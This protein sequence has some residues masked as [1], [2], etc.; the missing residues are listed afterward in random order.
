MDMHIYTHIY[1]YVYIHIYIYVFTP[2]HG[3]SELW[4]LDQFEFSLIA[5]QEEPLAAARK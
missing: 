5:T 3:V 2:H 1:I 4:Q